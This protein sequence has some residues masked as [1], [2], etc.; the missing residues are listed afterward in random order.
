VEYLYKNGFFTEF[1]FVNLNDYG[2]KSFL[3]GNDVLKKMVQKSSNTLMKEDFLLIL[4]SQKEI[5]GLGLSLVNNETLSYL[6]PSDVLAINIID[7][8]SYLRKKQ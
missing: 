8:G 5:L 1:K 3:Y 2:E 7:K 4:N 6:K